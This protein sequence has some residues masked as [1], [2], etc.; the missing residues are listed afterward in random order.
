MQTGSSRTLIA[1]KSGQTTYDFYGTEWRERGYGLRKTQVIICRQCLKC[2]M[3]LGIGGR[4]VSNPLSSLCRQC[5]FTEGC[6]VA[7]RFLGI[8]M[9]N[10]ARI[11]RPSFAKTSPKRSFSRKTGQRAAAD[12]NNSSKACGLLYI[13]L[14]AEAGKTKHVQTKHSIHVSQQQS[15]IMER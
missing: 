9:T 5:V 7:C 11:Y 3:Y 15:E 2:M 6:R 14:F 12:S 8:I 4:F 13:F 1:W 10:S